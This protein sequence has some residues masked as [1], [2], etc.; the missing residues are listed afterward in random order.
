M[1]LFSNTSIKALL[2]FLIVS[3]L[4]IAPAD[5]II[6]NSGEVLDEME[7]IEESEE[8]ITIRTIHTTM[9]IRRNRI[10][11]Y[12]I[13]PENR[14]QFYLNNARHHIKSEEWDK[15]RNEARKALALFPNCEEGF[16]LLREIEKS[17]A[18]KEIQ[19]YRDMLKEA[20]RFKE[21][22]LWE[23]ALPLYETITENITPTG[24]PSLYRQVSEEIAIV[25]FELG[26][27]QIE[28]NNIQEAATYFHNA[29]N[30][31]QDIA[32]IPFY[33][34]IAKELLD[35]PHEAL[36]HYKKAL[37]IDSRHSRAYDHLNKLEL[38]IE[39]TEPAPDVETDTNENNLLQP[40]QRQEEIIEEEELSNILSEINIQ[41]EE[42]TQMLNQ[43]TR[44]NWQDYFSTDYLGDV[45]AIV[46]PIIA[47]Y[48]QPVVIFILF[49]IIFWIIPNKHFE[50]NA[51]N[52]P[53]FLKYR[54]WVKIFG[55]LTYLF[56]LKE[57]FG[58]VF[59][60]KVKKGECPY[61]RADYTDF[62][63]WKNFDFNHCPHCGHE[64]E[65]AL[66]KPRDYLY[67]LAHDMAEKQELYHQKDKGPGHLIEKENITF[68]IQ[69]VLS[70]AID[71]RSTDL[72]FEPSADSLRIRNRVDGLLYDLVHVPMPLHA[73]IIS[74]IKIMATLDISEKR[75]P[76][77]G[78]FRFG[79]EGNSYD[80]R[81]ATAPTQFG[82]KVNLRILARHHTISTYE[83][84]GMEKADLEKMHTAVNKNYGLILSTGPTGSGKTTTLYTILQQLNTGDQNIITLEDPIE[85]E[86]KGINQMQVNQAAG[87]TFA[88]G[89]R[90]ILRQDPDIIM[91][92][93]IR[94]TETA[95]ISV[96]AALTG[97]LVL[98]TLH[99]IDAVSTITRLIDMNVDSSLFAG[100]L[101]IIIAQRLMRINCI[102]CS[103]AYHPD[104]KLL[105]RL[106]LEN[107]AANITFKKGKGCEECNN[108]GYL[109]R[110]GIF[111]IL[112]IDDTMKEL[113]EQEAGRQKILEHARACGMETLREKAI[114]K[115]LQGITTVEETIRVTG[116]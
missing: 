8:H 14:R 16:Y 57:Y 97:H 63:A 90:S 45:V 58:R 89:L 62:Y 25:Y 21:Y 17:I 5:I 77:D 6:L 13:N 98:S 85:Y 80:V 82:E 53:F 30:Y 111:E 59:S 34:G 39:E 91:V 106:N 20:R 11:S 69:A 102:Y 88:N 31:R 40:A 32:D 105:A 104:S 10:Q 56:Y 12:E 60:N 54:K 114:H 83:E 75:R 64:L 109:G 19:R 78:K 49:I 43:L 74:A 68:F 3:F 100:A 66:F 29:L 18:E 28:K 55:I 107:A 86:F 101:N 99:T 115:V 103:E 7:I 95:E 44:D 70:I 50:R 46:Q 79:R 71:F 22:F 36:G 112:V 47:D 37:E 26:K 23:E 108:I 61:C 2:I 94:D 38:L 24:H 27:V 35:K 73:S 67:E 93:E 4:I 51:L 72:H 15:A 81:A 87:F 92:G 110:T 48:W 84:L 113:I 116:V 41:E 1:I 33:L 52:K 65:K 96:N 42:Q 76:Q 9:N